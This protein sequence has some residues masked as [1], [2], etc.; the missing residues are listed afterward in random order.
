MKFGFPSGLFFPSKKFTFFCRVLLY[1]YPV[2]VPFLN[3]LP[4][5][6]VFRHCCSLDWLAGDLLAAPTYFTAYL[7]VVTYC[8]SR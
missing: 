1:L 7:V 5:A 2:N 3:S 8:C 4:P 6:L